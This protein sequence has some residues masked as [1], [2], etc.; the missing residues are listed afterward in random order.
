[1]I[2]LA[3]TDREGLRRAASE[4]RGL[5][6][7]AQTA[8]APADGRGERAPGDR[9]PLVV[10]D[11]GH[12]GIDPG[13][14]APDGTPE[15]DIVFA[16]S[17]K[18]QARLEAGGRYRVVMTRTSDVFVPLDERVRISR[19]AGADLFISIHA[20]TISAGAGVRGMTV[21]TGAE[22]ASDLESAR[23]AERENRADQAAGL[24]PGES[25]GDVADILQELTLRET[26]GFSHRFAG[27]LIADLKPVMPL[28]GHPHREARFRVLRAPD[29][30]AVLVEL[31][32]LSNRKDADLLTSEEWRERSAAAMAGAVDRFFA[33]RHA[34]QGVAPVSP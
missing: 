24:D 33:S 19:R 21:Y 8:T 3:R 10:I 9:R 2:E 16:F 17:Q 22:R 20:D 14:A 31:G 29:V 26:R 6:D 15:K 5:P 4:A 34:R 25:A 28:N 18:L 11:P 13:A 1:V 23:L 7:P 32:Y 30:P 12:G 27:K